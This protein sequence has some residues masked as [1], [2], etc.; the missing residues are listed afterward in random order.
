MGERAAV[1]VKEK[2]GALGKTMEE[3]VAAGLIP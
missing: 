3:L 1:V 2:A